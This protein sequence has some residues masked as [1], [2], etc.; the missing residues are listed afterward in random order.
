MGGHRS[1]TGWGRVGS[2]IIMRGLVE[3]GVVSVTVKAFGWYATALV[4]HKLKQYLCGQG[5]LVNESACKITRLCATV[6]ICATL[7]T[8]TDRCDHLI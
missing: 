7:C 5:S 3:M 2:D 6:T 8:Q 4:S 1:K